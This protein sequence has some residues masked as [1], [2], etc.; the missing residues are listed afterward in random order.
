MV[1]RYD[2][3]VLDQNAELED[4][5]E[6]FQILFS[7]DLIHDDDYFQLVKINVCLGVLHKDVIDLDDLKDL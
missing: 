1:I 6:S 2:Q 4:V 3:H 7:L 5:L